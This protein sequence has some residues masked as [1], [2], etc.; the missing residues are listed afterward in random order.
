MLL[1]F[2]PKIG[3]QSD[4]KYAVG[5]IDFSLMKSLFN[6]CAVDIQVKRFHIFS[7]SPTK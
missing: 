6:P 3:L 5:L 2:S 7:L 1:Q 4:H